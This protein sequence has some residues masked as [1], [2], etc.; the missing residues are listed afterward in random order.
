MKNLEVED[1][2]VFKRYLEIKEHRLSAFSFANIFIWK[3]LFKISWQII[4]D[5]LCVFMQDTVGCFMYLPALGKNVSGE[6]INKCFSIMDSLNSNKKFSRIENVEEDELDLYKSLGLREKFKT[7]EYLYKKDDL[8]SLSGNKYKSK[9]SSVNYFIKNYKFR[10]LEYG[11]KFKNECMELFKDWVKERKKINSDYIYQGML[12]SNYSTNLLAM[13]YYEELG[14][15]GRV[16][17]I[18]EEIKGYS[19]GFKL[20]KDTFCVLFEVV[21]LKLKGIAQYI[22]REFISN[23]N[24]F[25]YINV[26]DDSGLEN[27]K[28]VKNSYR[29]AELEPSYIMHRN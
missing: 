2:E 26:M 3:D 19:F 24:G 1:K 16:I 23:L 25:S 17:K 18:D 15:I 14:L 27:L 28:K 8:V 6:T 12:D 13:E 9:R 5:C 7:N 10:Y 4:D 20:N 11:P 29:P 22:F 21:D